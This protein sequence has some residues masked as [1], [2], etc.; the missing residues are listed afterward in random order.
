LFKAHFPTVLGVFPKHVPGEK[1]KHRLKSRNTVLQQISDLVL[2]N[3]RHRESSDAKD[4]VINIVP[5]AS[6]RGKTRIGRETALIGHDT[7]SSPSF[8]ILT[9]RPRFLALQKSDREVLLNALKR[10]VDLYITFSAPGLGPT[11]LLDSPD[12]SPE[13]R[14]GLRLAATG[15]LGQTSLETFLGKPRAEWAAYSTSNVFQALVDHHLA[16]SAPSA[17][18]VV[19]VHLDEIHEYLLVT[20]SYVEDPLDHLGRMVDTMVPSSLPAALRE[21][22]LPIIT[23]S[24]TGAYDAKYLR[25]KI[26]RMVTVLPP[27]SIESAVEMAHDYYKDSVD[28]SLWAA[29]AQDWSF[30]IALFDTGLLPYYIDQLLEAVPGSAVKLTTPWASELLNRLRDSPNTK[31]YWDLAAFG[32]TEALRLLLQLV[33]FRQ[34]VPRRFVFPKV[35]SEGGLDVRGL[36]MNGSV[37]LEPVVSE[38]GLDDEKNEVGLESPPFDASLFWINLP[39]ACI[40]ILNQK[41]PLSRRLLPDELLKLPSHD[42]PWRWQDFEQLF[43]HLQAGRMTGLQDIRVAQSANVRFRHAV[44][45]GKTKTPA[46]AASIEQEENKLLE[47]KSDMWRVKDIFPGAVAVG[48]DSLLERQVVLSGAYQQYTQAKQRLPTKSSKAPVVD[49]V[50]C[51]DRKEHRLSVGVHACCEGNA[52]VDHEF[53]CGSSPDQ[54]KILFV[55]QDKHS[56]KAGATHKASDIVTW[57]QQTR[58]AYVDWTTTHDLILVFFTNRRITGRVTNCP[59]LLIIA[60]HELADYL[61]PDLAGRGLLKSVSRQPLARVPSSLPVALSIQVTP[62]KQAH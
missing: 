9:T 59:S 42:F 43:G 13:L 41:L 53:E 3:H 50:A 40:K 51:H 20:K 35:T 14:M 1:L 45:R 21:R 37:N 32:G 23:L 7:G 17:H 49:R 61:G 27:L 26:G 62:V 39:F 31:R 52:L 46:I 12:V 60:S 5:G 10:S 47:L 30:R 11:P 25:S 15:V 6:G 36:E 57:Y 29:V 58:A 2:H 33:L 4:H 38:L 19:F 28:S 16:D 22:I 18:L 55:V 44:L 24:G 54:K 48:A 56:S 8:K 34:A